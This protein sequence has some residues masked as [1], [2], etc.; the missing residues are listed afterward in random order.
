[1][2]NNI[3]LAGRLTADAETRFTQSG[4]PVSNFTLAVD[5]L[6][7]GDNKETDFIYCTLWNRENLAPY[8]TKGK[9]I[10]VIGSIRAENYEDK[11]GNRRTKVYVLVR[12]V[13]FLPSNK[14][15]S[16]SQAEQEYQEV[17][18]TEDNLPF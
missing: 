1:M 6:K 14:A 17:P 4:K 8:L 13:V 3:S 18:F 15:E 5:R 10:G 2:L 11:E 12:E 9:A 7:Y 16:N